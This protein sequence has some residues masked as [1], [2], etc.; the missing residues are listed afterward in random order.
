MSHEAATGT[1][2]ILWRRLDV[3]GHESATLVA[4]GDGPR[5]SGAAVFAEDGVPSHACYEV[6]CDPGWKTRAARVV[7]WHGTHPIDLTIEADGAG[8]WW[9]NGASQ[10]AVRGT[11]DLDL[12]ITPSTN[13]L[14]LRRLRIPVGGREEVAAAWLDWPKPQLQRLVQR[15]HRLDQHRFEY[16]ADLASGLFRGTIEVGAAALV[17]RYGS[18]WDMVLLRGIDG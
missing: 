17:T 13:T 1:W 11:L 3:A 16:E 7:G 12:A 10:P 14:S 2:R 15:Y 8:S 6:R 4:T 5:L 18:L 9:V